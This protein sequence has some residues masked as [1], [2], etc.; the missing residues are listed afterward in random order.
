MTVKWFS[1]WYIASEWW[2][3]D[4]DLEHSIFWPYLHCKWSKRQGL[5]V[6]LGIDTIC[7]PLLSLPQHSSLIKNSFSDKM[8][9]TF[10]IGIA[11][12]SVA[13]YKSELFPL[14]LLHFVFRAMTNKEFL[15]VLGH[16]VL[17]ILQISWLFLS[18]EY[19]NRFR[20]HSFPSMVIINWEDK[21]W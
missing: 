16:P 9:K 21:A 13:V 10:F 1:P 11:I 14:N 20:S 19:V 12:Y 3:Q 2:S 6:P 4:S 18:K 5:C 7:K 17:I 8:Y 15:S